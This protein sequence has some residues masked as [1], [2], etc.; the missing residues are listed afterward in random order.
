MLSKRTYP[1]GILHQASDSLLLADLDGNCCFPIHIAF[2][3]LRPDITI[4]SNA[5]RKVIIVELTCPCEE[6]WNH[7][8]VLRSTST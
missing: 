8:T 1:V 6:T 4:F 3:Q 5:S 2:T 7:G